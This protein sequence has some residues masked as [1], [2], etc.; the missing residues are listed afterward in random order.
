MPEEENGDTR[1]SLDS[2]G[3]QLLK[4]IN[5]HVREYDLTYDAVIGCVEIIKLTLWEELKENECG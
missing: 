1:A 2:L 4:V 3:E 5:Y